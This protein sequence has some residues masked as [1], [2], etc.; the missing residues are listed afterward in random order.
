[1]ANPGAPKEVSPYGMIGLKVNDKPPLSPRLTE[2]SRKPMLRQKMGDDLRRALMASGVLMLVIA[3]LAAIWF[4]ASN[5]KPTQ[6]VTHKAPV[7]AAL[8]PPTE[9]DYRAWHS[10]GFAGSPGERQALIDEAALTAKYPGLARRDGGSLTIYDRGKTITI[11]KAVSEPNSNSE[12]DSYVIVKVLIL[13]DPVVRAREP[14]AVVSCHLGEFGRNMLILPSGA[15]LEVGDASASPDGNLLVIGDDHELSDNFIKLRIY[16]WPEMKSFVRFEPFCSFL[17]WQD[18]THFA[19][20]CMYGPEHSL[21][22]FYARVS[23]D[24]NDSWQMVSTA[25]LSADGHEVTTVPD[26]ATRGYPLEKD[27][28]LHFSAKALTEK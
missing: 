20:S 8:T 11:L 28:H 5:I 6:T 16:N 26:L 19:V 17:A 2:N 22:H 27:P 14:F 13:F 23:Q 4:A 9:A 10:N 12:C 18:E 21:R 3:P 7:K 25:E 1:M 15:T 24:R